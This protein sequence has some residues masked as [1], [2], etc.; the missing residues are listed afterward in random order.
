MHFNNTLSNFCL[1]MCAGCQV[2]LVDARPDIYAGT[3][4]MLRENVRSLSME[5]VVETGTG[6]EQKLTVKDNVCP[7]QKVKCSGFVT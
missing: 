6:S 7:A 2:L 4:T 3:I 5:G 1:Q